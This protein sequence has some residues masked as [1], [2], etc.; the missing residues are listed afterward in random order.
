[1][2]R[3]RGKAFWRQLLKSSATNNSI[4]VNI[5]SSLSYIRLECLVNTSLAKDNYKPFAFI[6]CDWSLASNASQT[7]NDYHSASQTLPSASS[8][9]K[10][11]THIDN[12]SP[13]RKKHVSN[14]IHESDDA[15]CIHPLV[16]FFANHSICLQMCA[17]FSWCHSAK[18]SYFS[19]NFICSVI[20]EAMWFTCFAYNSVFRPMRL[21]ADSTAAAQIALKHVHQPLILCLCQPFSTKD[22]SA[23]TPFCGK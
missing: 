7:A 6:A 19:K 5:P 2:K 23:K 1:M 9:Y 18:S 15:V 4:R 16:Q 11:F 21:L 13:P 22:L 20:C 14:R 12:N 3:F 8:K 10:R 17:C